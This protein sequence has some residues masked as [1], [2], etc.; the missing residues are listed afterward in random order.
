MSDTRYIDELVMKARKAQSILDGYSQEQVDLIAAAIVFHLSRP[1]LATQIAEMA[2]EETKMGL[3]ESKRSKLTQKMPAIF[4][5]IRK[6]KTVGV[7]DR[8]EEN[9]ITT[10]AKPFGVIAALVPSTNCEATP[11]FKS[12]LG[13]RARNAVIC[14]PHPS[15]KTTTQ[16]VVNVI[17]GI[18]RSLNAPEDLVQCIDTPSKSL[19]NELMAQCDLTM[20]TG[21][22]DMVKAA[23]S[24]GR[25]AYGVGVGNAAVIIDETADLEDAA[26]KIRIGKTGDNASGCSAENSVIIQASVYDDFLRT[27]K[28]QGAYIVSSAD[29]EKLQAVMWENG[30]VS[31]KVVARPVSEIAALAELELPADTSFIVVEET[32]TGPDYPFS[33][34]KLSLVLTCYKYEDFDEAVSLVNKITDYSGSGHSCGIHSNDSTRIL[35]LGLETRTSRVIVRQPHGVA[36][37]GSWSNGLAKTFSLGCGSWGGN[38]TSENVTQKHYYNNTRIAEP[39]KHTAPTDDASIYGHLLDKIANLRI[40]MEE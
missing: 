8:D 23:Y 31:R 9:G 28:E 14:A 3:V 1:D 34:E 7:I 29:K 13:I 4:H 25:P 21:S 30:H 2:Y 11:I 38:S 17:R 37:S 36:N 33:G 26:A 5:D 39:I 35:K 16:F 6:E 20:A 12:V 15:S 18:L 22:G 24:S 19:A 40:E 10:I 32:G 27:L